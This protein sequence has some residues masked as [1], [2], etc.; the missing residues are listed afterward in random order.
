MKKIVFPFLLIFGHLFCNA[1]KEY[2]PGSIYDNLPFEL[3]PINTPQFPDRVIKPEDFGGKADGK[4]DNT[5]AFAKA[6]DYLSNLGGGTLEIA[7]GTWITGPIVLKSNVHLHTQADTRIIFN[8]NRDM[9]PLVDGNYEGG[10]SKRCQSNISA[11]NAVNIAITGGGIFDGS[12]QVWRPVKKSKVTTAMWEEL[13]SSGGVLNEKKNMWFPS[14]SSLRGEQIADKSNLSDKGWKDIKDFLRPTMLNLISCK[15]ILLADITVTNSPSWTVH[16]LLCENLIISSVTVENP[17]YGQNTDA[18]DIESCKNVVIYNST[19]DV[20]DDG[21]CI[22]SGKDEFGRKRGIPSENI[23][24]NNCTV[25]KGHGGF[26][27]GSEMSGGARNIYVSNCN[28]N[29]TSCGLRF[30]STR[31]RG[32]VVENIYIDKIKMKNI[33]GDAIIFD[34]FYGNKGARTTKPRDITT[35]S[36]KNIYMKELTGMRCKRAV[37]LNGLPEMNLTNIVLENSDFTTEDAGFIGDADGVRLKNIT[38]RTPENSTLKIENARNI[39]MDEIQFPGKES[40]ILNISGKTESISV[41]HSPAL[42]I[43]DVSVHA[44]ASHP[45]NSR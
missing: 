5:A 38:F 41:E 4:S 43:E 40:Q 34:L 33:D 22:K 28:F 30:K 10:K 25:L 3:K 26:V 16:P 35:P 1:Q 29:G 13:I 7:G 24:V 32:G 27:I 14:H 11:E 19:V 2:V 39:N 31:G 37:Y 44:T 8:T 42:K 36:F 20:G 23:L 21:I 45:G 15:N 18:I 6:I 17:E 9:Y 12:G